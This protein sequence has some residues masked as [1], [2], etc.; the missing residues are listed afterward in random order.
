MNKTKLNSKDTEVVEES[1]IKCAYKNIYKGVKFY[2]VELSSKTALG[3][4]S[5]QDFKLIKF[6]D[7]IKH[8]S[9]GKVQED[10]DSKKS[11]AKTRSIKGLSDKALKK[12][13]EVKRILISSMDLEKL[14]KNITST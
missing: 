6:M 9:S 7:E 12:K 3:L 2:I 14:Q 13:T 1:F 10:A 5:C 4:E 8:S 11:E